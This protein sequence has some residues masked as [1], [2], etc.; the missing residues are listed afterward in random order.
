M[1]YTSVTPF[2]RAR[3][4]ARVQPAQGPLPRITVDKWH[5]LREIT[6]ARS[7]FGLSDRDIAVLQALFSF[8]P[9]TRLDA[10]ANAPVVFPSNKSICERL[11]GMACS[12]MRRHLARLVETGLLLRR[13]SPNGKR[14]SRRAGKDRIAFGFDLSPILTRFDEITQA[15]DD[16]RNLHARIVELRETISLMRRDLLA[17]AQDAADQCPDATEPQ[18]V[19]DLCALVA[20]AL[21][22]KLTLDDLERI[23]SDLADELKAFERDKEV[24][25]AENLSINVA[26]NEQHQQSTLTELKESEEHRNTMVP[27][28]A[29]SDRPDDCLK[30]TPSLEIVLHACPE[31]QSY[32]ATPVRTWHEFVRAAH[33]VRPMMGIPETLWSACLS[34]MGPESASVVLA[35]MLERFT[36][37]KS[38]G[39]YLQSLLTRARN[40]AFSPQP[41]LQAL[42]NAKAA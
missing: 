16:A 15:A 2:R 18:T 37:I 4:A 39:A 28:T 17:L 1:G 22:R 33:I 13:D 14:Y 30:D 9:E 20:R 21:R 31:I 36:E 11:G 6:T 5:A 10:S 42:I 12:T 38:P 34:V 8:H 41:M 26:I 32:N 3:D 19:I 27:N 24:S 25:C 7:A 23:A 40:G 35:A 29:I